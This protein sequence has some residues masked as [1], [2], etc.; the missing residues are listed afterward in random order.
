MQHE[1]KGFNRAAAADELTARMR[2]SAPDG[3]VIGEVAKQ[4]LELPPQVTE[5][6]GGA[7]AGWRVK[8]SPLDEGN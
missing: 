4:P 6:G 1:P 8:W 5:S 2:G 7:P 3:Q